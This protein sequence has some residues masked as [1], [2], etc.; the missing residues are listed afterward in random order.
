MRKRE[1]DYP[2]DKPSF[3]KVGILMLLL[4][5]LMMF[6]FLD[7]YFFDDEE[8]IDCDP[9]HEDCDKLKIIV[10]FIGNYKQLVSYT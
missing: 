1:E 4:L 5:V 2:P 3:Q 7:G 9:E 8:D 10:R 6:W